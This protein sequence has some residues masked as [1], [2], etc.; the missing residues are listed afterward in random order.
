MPMSG[1]LSLLASSLPPPLAPEVELRFAHVVPS[2][3]K[4]LPLPSSCPLVLLL[5]THSPYPDLG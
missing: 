1:L 2:S 4:V 5:P 3:R